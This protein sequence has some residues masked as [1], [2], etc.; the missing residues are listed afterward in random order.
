MEKE[1]GLE[2]ILA[3][4]D[5]VLT[6]LP[7]TEDRYEQRA[8]ILTTLHQY[9]EGLYTIFP[10]KVETQADVIERSEQMSLFSLVNG[11]DVEPG[12]DRDGFARIREE[13]LPEE[14]Q[15]GMDATAGVL[16]ASPEE[17]PIQAETLEAAETLTGDVIDT[18]SGEV[19]ND[20][21][22]VS[23]EV[24]NGIESVSGETINDIEAVSGEATDDI[25][26]VQ[27]EVI[28]DIETVGGEIIDIPVDAIMPIEES[29][30]STE[31]AVPQAPVA[32]SAPINYRITD[33]DLG[34]GS[35]VEFSRAEYCSG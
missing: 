3:R 19:I 17:S 20:M 8:A 21:E 1:G 30:E 27:G 26:A 7:A 29:A 9:A 24:T 10:Q 14:F 16:P 12:G 13:D 15:A 22:A 35:P 28:D 4:M 2:E 18:S 31:T 32:A 34:T 5:E 6:A 25:E 23:G 11:W 33:D